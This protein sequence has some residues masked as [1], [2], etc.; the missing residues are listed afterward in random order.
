MLSTNQ[1]NIARNYTDLNQERDIVKD[2]HIQRG[3]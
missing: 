2:K 1:N 3:I